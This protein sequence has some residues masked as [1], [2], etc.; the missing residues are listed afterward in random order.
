MNFL[1][2]LSK[3]LPLDI[4]ESL[5]LF[6]DGLL[7]LLRLLLVPQHYLQ[8]HIVLHFLNLCKVLV[9]KIDAGNLGRNL[10]QFPGLAV[11]PFVISF[12]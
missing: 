6:L 7:S 11:Y 3:V 9:F 8:P 5:Y 1:E 10:E 12:L 2:S 4:W